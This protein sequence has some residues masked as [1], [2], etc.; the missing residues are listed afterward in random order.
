MRVPVAARSRGVL[1]PLATAVAGL[2]SGLRAQE[3]RLD[4]PAPRALVFAYENGRWYDGVGF[5]RR[6][7]YV[8]DGTL[9]DDAPGPVDVRIDLREQFV[10]PPYGEGHNH[11]LEADVSGHLA[12]RVRR[13]G[14][15]LHV[16]L[17]EVGLV[18]E[19]ARPGAFEA[20]PAATMPDEAH[21]ARSSPMPNGR[22]RNHSS[23]PLWVVGNDRGR[24]VARRLEPGRETPD[25]LDA[26]GFRAVDGTPIDGHDAWVKIIDLATADVRDD[27]A[28][29]KRGCFLCKSVGDREFRTGPVR[30]DGRLRAAARLR[31]V[32]RPGPSACRPRGRAAARPASPPD[33][34]RGPAP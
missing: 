34:R 5:E 7:F 2:L 14:L 16:D 1:A 21:G 3:A 30:R 12:P 15:V 26:D 22:V 17:H 19:E 29:L 32:V 27:G 33:A 4:A 8:V 10:V 23:R 9:A 6:T 25:G 18:G 24:P 11:L 31:P 13:V 28:E 20:C